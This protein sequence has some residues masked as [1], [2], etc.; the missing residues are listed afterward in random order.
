MNKR[1]EKEM[2][3]NKIRIEEVGDGRW[4]D[5]NRKNIIKEE[6]ERR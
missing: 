1:E 3:I 6:W 5:K 2:N 4:Q